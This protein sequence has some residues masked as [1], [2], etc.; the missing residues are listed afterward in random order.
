M[1]DNVIEMKMQICS[2]IWNYSSNYA[3][4]FLYKNSSCRKHNW[5][6]IIGFFINAALRNVYFIIYYQFTFSSRNCFFEC[7]HFNEYSIRMSL[8][9]F[10]LRKLPSIN[11]YANE[12]RMWGHPQYLELRI[13]EGSVTPHVYL[14]T[15]ITSFHV[16]GSI[17]VL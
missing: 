6:C 12:G 13:G 8:Y 16:F 14:C 7:L 9:V 10:W 2:I 5:R 11:T 4:V 17:F 1:R 15:Y 3:G